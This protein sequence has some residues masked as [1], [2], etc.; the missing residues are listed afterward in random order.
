MFLPV[1]MSG[2]KWLSGLV[3]EVSLTLGV[4]KM[5]LFNTYSASYKGFKGGL[6]KMAN[7]A[8]L[9]TGGDPTSSMGG[10]VR[11]CCPLTG[12]VCVRWWLTCLDSRQIR[13]LS[14]SCQTVQEAHG[15]VG[16]PCQVRSADHV[17]PY[18]GGTGPQVLKSAGCRYSQSFAA[19]SRENGNAFIL[20]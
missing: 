9:C 11:T 17:D 13:L 2:Y 16:A 5:C 7:E 15:G 10:P 4:P 1:S 3:R 6:N 8:S 19:P 18:R 14:F 12:V 20:M